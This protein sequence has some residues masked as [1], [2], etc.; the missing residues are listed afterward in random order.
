MSTGNLSLLRD[1]PPRGLLEQAETRHEEALRV[2]RCMDTL[3]R[4]TEPLNQYRQWEI[5]PNYRFEVGCRFDLNGMRSD[6]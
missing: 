3:Q 2:D 5:D 1:V 6:P 4:V